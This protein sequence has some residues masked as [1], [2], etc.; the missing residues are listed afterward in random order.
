M[1][2]YRQALV[3]ASRLVVVPNLVCI[4]L[5]LLVPVSLSRSCRWH[6]AHVQTTAPVI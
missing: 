4:S 6:G 3:H 5:A 1:E 2:P